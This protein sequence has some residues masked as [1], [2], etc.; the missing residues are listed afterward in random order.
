MLL[1]CGERCIS[2]YST[3]VVVVP[4][5]HDVTTHSPVSAP[6]VGKMEEQLASWMYTH[7]CEYIY[8]CAFECVCMCTYVCVFVCN[9]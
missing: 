8:V 4:G 9:S 5:H 3:L 6:A 2:G 7:V 1:E